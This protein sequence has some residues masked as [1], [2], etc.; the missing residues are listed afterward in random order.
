MIIRELESDPR[1]PERLEP[2]RQCAAEAARA[3]RAGDLRALGQALTRNTGAQAALH[4]D[5]AGERHR[6]VIEQAR[7]YAAWGWK[8][9]G[10]GGAGGSVAILS[11]PD[12]SRKREMEEA[13]LAADPLFRVIPVA[14]RREGLR[15]WESPAG[16]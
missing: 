4:P 1:G 16:D 12:R 9:N 7:R 15:V 2:I 8:V 13:I 14:I 11:H 10:A 5:L 6:R 3:M